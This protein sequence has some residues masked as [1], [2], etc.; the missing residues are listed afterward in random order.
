MNIIDLIVCLV[1]F[2]AVWNG[3]RKGFVVQMG[4]LAALIAGLWLAWRYGPAAGE[5]LRLDA[6]VRAPGGFVVVL[7]VVVVAVA[8]AGRMLR[9]LFRFAGFGWLDTM[10]GIAVAA[11]KYLLLLS[12]LFVAFDRLNADYSLV[13]RRTIDSSACYRPVMRLSEWVFPFVEQV[14]DR[15]QHEQAQE[16]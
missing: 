7:L 1:L 9:K 15:L 4:A 8:V 2:V 12:A 10:L 16:I 13:G 3:W 5:W 14:S 11:F 6:S